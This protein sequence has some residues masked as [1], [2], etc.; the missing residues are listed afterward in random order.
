MIKEALA[1]LVDEVNKYLSQKL[2]QDT[3][4][5]LILGNV[6]KVIDND[7]G[8]TGNTATNKAILS[9]VNIEEDR[10]SKS[11]D[12]FRKVDDKIQYKN[13]KIFLNLYLLF[14]VNKSDYSEALKLLANVIQFFQYRFVFD[15][16]NSPN[17]DPKIERIIMDLHSLNFEQMNHLWGILGGKYLPSV[18]Y[19]MRVVGIEDETADASAEPIKEIEINP[20]TLSPR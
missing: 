14:A 17:L 2:G 10:F 3:E 11:P 1:F 6:V 13:P 12:N 7:A 5:R 4:S 19:K 18:L 15:L 16:Q 20:L 9:L 8:A